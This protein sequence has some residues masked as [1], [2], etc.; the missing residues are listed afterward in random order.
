[1]A[2]VKIR[3]RE[4]VFDFE[5]FVRAAKRL[6]IIRFCGLNHSYRSFFS[7][8]ILFVIFVKRTNLAYYHSYYSSIRM[9]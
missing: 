5:S 6:R 1:M 3:S 8:I 2:L 9:S 7:I 4:Q